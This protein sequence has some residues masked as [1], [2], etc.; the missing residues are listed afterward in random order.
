LL[1]EL[2]RDQTSGLKQGPLSNDATTEKSPYAEALTTNGISRQ[3][4]HRY[5]A[6]AAVPDAGLFVRN[7]HASLF[8]K[9]C[10]RH[11]KGGGQRRHYGDCRICGAIFNAR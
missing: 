3:T 11:L 10:N 1:A 9:L 4:A 2:A 5:R 6:L 8:E 7:A